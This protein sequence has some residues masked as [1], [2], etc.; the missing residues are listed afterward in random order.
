[1]PRPIRPPWTGTAL[2]TY[3][4]YLGGDL[5]PLAVASTPAEFNAA[6][7]DRARPDMVGLH[8]TEVLP[9]FRNSIWIS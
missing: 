2:V 7:I 8:M 6:L 1:V 4:H 3:N 5:A 9:E